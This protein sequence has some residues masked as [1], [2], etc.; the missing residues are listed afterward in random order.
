[1][2]P[3]HLAFKG[4]M[5]RK[6]ASIDWLCGFFYV[7]APVDSNSNPVTGFRAISKRGGGGVHPHP[8]IAHTTFQF[9]IP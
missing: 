2:P 9:W 7:R 6:H 1:M 3:L 8:Q 5:Q 4:F